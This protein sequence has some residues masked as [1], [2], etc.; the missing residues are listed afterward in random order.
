MPLPLGQG[1][2]HLGIPPGGGDVEGDGPLHAVEVVVEAGGR[3][4]KQ[5]GG[6]PAEVE[7][8][9]EGVLKHPAL[10]RLMAFWVS[11]RFSRG[12]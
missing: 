6:D 11:Y 5:G 2:D 9:A 1:V 4:H 7:V 3:L 8:A 12:A 10:R